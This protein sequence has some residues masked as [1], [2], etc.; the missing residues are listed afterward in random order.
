[1]DSQ[2]SLVDKKFMPMQ[3]SVDTPL[4]LGVDA[5]LDLVVS[6]PIQPMIMLMQYLTNTTPIFGGDASLDLVVLHPIQPMVEE[7]VVSMQS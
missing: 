1:L 4:P 5:S 7:V 6:H 3:S 2:P